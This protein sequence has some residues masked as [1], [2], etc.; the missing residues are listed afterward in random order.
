MVIKVGEIYPTNNYGSLEVVEYINARKILVRFINTGY[1][2]YT[3]AGHMRDGVV[4]DPLY[5]TI[6]GKGYFGVGSY[7]SWTNG[8]ITK[9]YKT[10][11]NMLQRCYDEKSLGNNPTYK[12]CTVVK[13]WHNFQVFGKWFDNNYI[14]GY[15]IDKDIKVPGNRVYGPDTCT[16][17]THME[18]SETASAVSA[19]F[20]TPEGKR[21]EVYNISKFARENGLSGSGL[22]NVKN[23]KRNHHKG[24]TLWKEEEK[25][26]GG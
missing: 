21:I 3:S 12:G 11:N 17:V 19:I 24:W 14:E 1:E 8:K 16:F 22:S 9:V 23:G 26:S 18:N 15:Q 10:W 5:P 7:K 2:K 6:F 20:R 4:K 13:E 25:Q